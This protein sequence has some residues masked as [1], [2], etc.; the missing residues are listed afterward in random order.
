MTE[1]QTPN[2]FLEKIEKVFEDL[3]NELEGRI[4]VHVAILDGIANS[5]MGTLTAA[6]EHFGEPSD[7]NNILPGE[8]NTSV[9][10]QDYLDLH[11]M[12]TELANKYN[13]SSVQPGDPLTENQGL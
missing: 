12:Y 3:K 8:D 6:A 10:F 2:T 9:T 4:G 7:R 5:K 11:A 1:Q 13:E